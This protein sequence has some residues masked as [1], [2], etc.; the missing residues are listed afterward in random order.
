[1]SAQT[2]YQFL[3]DYHWHVNQRL[4]DGAAKLD[5]DSYF[6]PS[7]YGRTPHQLLFHIFNTMR[8]W[9]MSLETGKQPHSLPHE[10][11]PDLASLQ[12]AF[13][14]EQAAWTAVLQNHSSEQIEGEVELMSL[15]GSMFKIPL[16]R[17]LQHLVLH[18]MQH[19]TE[20]AQLLTARGHSPGDID[21]IFYEGAH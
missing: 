2:Q 1:M 19:H 11:Y 13:A 16:W 15:R 14:D 4:V 3:F 5:Q 12:A 8:S 7:A 10:N 18:G 21:F 17:V 20:L 9:R 6:E